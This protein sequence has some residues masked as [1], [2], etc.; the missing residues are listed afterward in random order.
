[1]ADVEHI[2]KYRDDDTYDQ[3]HIDSVLALKLV[4]VEAIRKA[5]FSMCGIDTINS[6]GGI[7]L[8]K[9]FKALGVKPCLWLEFRTQWL[10][11]S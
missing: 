3:K 7:I 6:V 5:D 11:Q 2:G 1:M 9:L 4:D 8:P 10:F